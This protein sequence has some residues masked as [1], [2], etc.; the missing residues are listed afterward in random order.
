MAVTVPRP[1]DHVFNFCA[2]ALQAALARRITCDPGS[3]SRA[4]WGDLLRLPPHPPS[5]FFLTGDLAAT[6]CAPHPPIPPRRPPAPPPPAIWRRPP[7]PPHPP[8]AHDLSP[9]SRRT[10]ASPPRLLAHFALALNVQDPVRCGQGQGVMYR[11]NDMQQVWRSLKEVEELVSKQ[12][13]TDTS[14]L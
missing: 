8:R 14:Q 2:P 1:S 10:P 5:R 12:K 13:V 4:I 9:P 6:F 7:A 3:S 11:S